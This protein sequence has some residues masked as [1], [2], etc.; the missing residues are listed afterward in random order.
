MR[1]GLFRIKKRLITLN[2]GGTML[3]PTFTL[4]KLFDDE[5]YLYFRIFMFRFSHTFKPKT[6]SF[7]NEIYE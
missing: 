1:L 7:E 6:R 3:L 5:W 2:E 4:H